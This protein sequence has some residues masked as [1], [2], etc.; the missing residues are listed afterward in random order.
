M[1][2]CD[3]RELILSWALLGAMLVFA[4]V[5][6]HDAWRRIG[7]P[8]WG[9][10][11]LENRQVGPGGGERAGLQPWD[12]VV[13]VEGHAVASVDAIRAEVA[14]HP[15]GSALRYTIQRRG[16]VVDAEIPTRVVTIG[17]FKRFLVDSLMPG[18]FVLVIG[19]VVLHLKPGVPAT[20]LFL[21][22]CVVSAVVN[23]GFTDFIT[24]HRF[25]RVFLGVWPW[26]AAIL[27]HLALTF[28]EPRAIVRRH[29]WIVWP[30]YALSGMLAVL[31]QLTFGYQ[32]VAAGEIIAGYWGLAMIALVVSLGRTAVVG[33]TALVRQRARVLELGFALGYLLPVLGTASEAVFGVTVPYLTQLWKLN[34]LF[35]LVVAYAIVRYQ[36]FDIGAVLRAGTIYSAVTGLVLLGYAGML[37]AVNVSF[38]QLG[39]AVSPVIPAAVASLAVVLF[40]NPVYVRTQAFLDRVFF[41]QRHDAQQALERLA[42]SMT[43]VLELNVIVSLIAA[44]VHEVLHPARV[45]V[46]LRE[47]GRKTFRTVDTADDVVSLAEDAALPACLA[48]RRMMLTRERLRDD[49][50]LADVRDACLAEMD[51][52]GAEVVAPV[53]FRDRVIGL[54]ALGPKRSGTAYTS[55]DLKLLRILVNQS[56]VAL[57]NAKAYTALQAALR[58]VQILESIR[59]NLAKFVPRTVQSLIEAAPEAPAL[60]KRDADVSVLFVDIAGYTRLSERLD[61]A[62]VNTLVE[63]YFGAF[64]DEVLRHGGDVNET[65]GDGLMVIFQDADPRRHARAAVRAA[66]AILRRAR[67]INAGQPEEE[68]IALHAGV[69]SGVAGVGATKIEGTAGTRWTY[70]A[71]GP[72]TN[73]AARLAALGDGEAIMV[74]AETRRRLETEP[75]LQDVGERRL[76][77]VEEPVRVYRLPAFGSVDDRAAVALPAGYQ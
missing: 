31:L 8:W 14:R 41:R 38:S 6:T 49:P 45:G 9:F 18:L 25:T 59:A 11:L 17:D 48:G 37:T 30:P 71:S 23:I 70:T 13:A 72:V 21:A 1:R 63:R 19:A 54:L 44:A 46:L 64:L 32:V 74:G 76:K 22:F 20:R 61:S 2:R 26:S 51:A 56:A 60:A 10:A 33:S 28:P 36:L 53:S 34:F 75:G 67:E 66:L 52:L 42:D 50:D 24:T 55:E 57:E 65:A 4:A 39:M 12:L 7:Q 62:T 68:Q 16:E 47:D 77:N 27:V 5:A 29:L 69:N 15:A 3:G 43:T 35:P 58:R 40:L 73:I